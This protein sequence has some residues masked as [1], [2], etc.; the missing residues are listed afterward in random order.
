VAI[1]NPDTIIQMIRTDPGVTISLGLFPKNNNASATAMKTK[2]MA[3]ENQP[4][5]IGL[6]V[7]GIRMR[8]SPYGPHL[9]LNYDRQSSVSVGAPLRAG[10]TD[11]AGA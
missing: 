9:L 3:K 1:I 5:P 10:A 8:Y 2:A 4:E 6:L 11:R 7:R